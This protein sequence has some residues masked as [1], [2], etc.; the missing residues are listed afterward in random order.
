MSL[1]LR[2]A[3]NPFFDQRLR[4][5]MLAVACVF[6]V[7]LLRLFQLQILQG[8]ELKRRSLRNSIRSIRLEAP[9]GEILDRE[10]RVL[11]TTRPAFHLDLVP[12]ELRDAD[13]TF[14]A[15]ARLLETDEASLRERLGEP[16]GRARFQP[17]RLVPDL[18][19]PQ[20]ARVEAH[21]FKLPGVFTEIR[22]RRHYPEGR[23]AAHVLGTLGE[24]DARRLETREFTGYRAGDVIGQ[25]GVEALLETHLRGRA[26][27]RNV[28]VDVAGREVEVL[29]EV[30]PRPGRGAVLTLDLD[31]QRAAEEALAAAAPEGE[32]SS[33]ALVALDP[34][35]GE[36][37]ALASHPA[38]DPND[39]AGELDPDTW[40]ALTS[41]PQRP[42]QNRALAGQYPPG[43]TYKPFVAAAGLAER[44]LHA[45]D[46]VFCPGSFR[47][48][49]RV[50]RCWRRSGHGPVSL[51][52]ALVRSCDVYFYQAG[53]ELGVDRL[54][55]HARRFGFGRPTGIALEGEKPG[56]V[57]TSLWK[58]QRF[59]EPWVRGET[60]SVSIGQGFNLATPL[61]MAVAY[62][63][64]ANGGLVLRPRLIL[65]LDG[66]RE[67]GAP[68]EPEVRGRLGLDPAVLARIRSALRGVVAEREGTGGRARVP[69]V[70]VAGKTGTSQVVR[71]EHTEGMEEDEVPRQLRDHAWFA[72]FAPVED[73]E[74][75]VAVLVEH[76][77]SGGST[78]APVAQRVLARYFEKQQGEEPLP[79][80]EAKKRRS[81]RRDAEARVAGR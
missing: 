15:L 6:L 3:A 16:T 14:M 29:D 32:P 54:A 21:S 10:G 58:E 34:R 8:D 1:G 49:R 42:F 79:T 64:L 70:E 57:P 80:R 40:S 4:V 50:Y 38:F 81:E 19:W 62:A 27:G 13:L 41:D 46:L 69:G 5:A 23:L 53:L 77:G 43:S 72:A 35:S 76:G 52:D 11:V 33:G 71:L 61:Q 26:G 37:L 9:R 60:V 12:S 45:Q 31:L 28:V 22:P 39:F 18:S 17:V 59:Q 63:A 55:E 74:I 7:F 56:L 20:L 47:L 51:H 73:T 48:G 44:T 30:E 67:P 65:R 78:A 24:I 25:S 75:V 36:I 68:L 2:G 66:E